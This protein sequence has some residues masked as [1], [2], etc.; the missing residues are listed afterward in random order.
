MNTDSVIVGEH[1]P[2]ELWMR[3]LVVE[4]LDAVPQACGDDIDDET[5]VELAKPIVVDGRYAP[6]CHRKD[7]PHV[8]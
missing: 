6:S 4:F 2:A 1:L 3:K 8:R 5:V 7:T